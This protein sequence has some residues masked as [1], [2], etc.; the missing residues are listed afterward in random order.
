MAALTQAQWLEKLRGLVPSDIFNE[1]P[2]AL[3]VFSGIAKVLEGVDE[4][5]QDHFNAT[6]ITRANTPVLQAL[7]DERGITQLPGESNATYAARMQR[8]TSQTDLL[9]IRDAVN[10]LLAIGQCRILEAPQDA[11]YCSRGNF[12]S[13]NDYM[14]N[15][16]ANEFLVVVPPQ[17]HSGYTFASRGY[18]ASRGAF[19]GSGDTLSSLYASI[20]AVINRLKAFGVLYGIVESSN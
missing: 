19:T 17:T 6:F 11:P 15:F 8:I 1:E 10:A 16:R 20:I 4:D 9:D 3:A 12:C 7:G 14:L 13:R 2:Q 18:F 5:T